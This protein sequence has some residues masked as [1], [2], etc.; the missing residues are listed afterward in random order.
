LGKLALGCA[1]THE[2]RGRLDLRA[3]AA[4]LPA[5]PEERWREGF[6]A[7]PSARS[8]LN[9]LGEEERRALGQEIARRMVSQGRALAGGR[10]EIGGLVFSHEGEVLGLF[11]SWLEEIVGR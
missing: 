7:A 1:D 3:L 6:A 10:L 11:P 5:K 4:V 8:A 2:R 9:L